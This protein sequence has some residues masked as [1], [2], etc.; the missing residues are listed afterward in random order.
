MFCDLDINK[1]YFSVI[2]N[3]KKH[4]FI[5]TDYDKSY[6][7]KIENKQSLSASEK[8]KI[9]KEYGECYKW[10]NYEHDI[11]FI[12]YK[13]YIDDTIELL[14]KKIFVSIFDDTE[15]KYILPFNQLLYLK[16]GKILGNHF[17]NVNAKELLPFKLDNRFVDDEGFPKT[18][19]LVTT[20]NKL[21]FDE[22]NIYDKDQFDIYLIN[23]MD[24]LKYLKKE[25]IIIDQKVKYG[26]LRKFFTK[27]KLNIQTSLCQ[28]KIENF[29]NFFSK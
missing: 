22:I 10:Y 13:I 23:I 26:Y 25:N 18:V 15:T 19:D 3:K 5:G 11:E 27:Y 1:P 14:Q 12:K 16:N 17:I 24:V 8:S 6:F 20:T 21:I 7:K 4:V 29:S 9:D 2:K 28:T